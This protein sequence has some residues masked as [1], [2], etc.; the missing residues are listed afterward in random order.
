[1]RAICTALVI[2][3]LAHDASANRWLLDLEPVAIHGRTDGEVGPVSMM[4]VA[5][6]RVFSDGAIAPYAAVGSGF[7]TIQARGGVMIAPRDQSG[8]IAR[9]ELRPQIATIVCAEPAILA[10]AGGGYRWGDATRRRVA[11]IGSVAGGPAWLADDCGPDTTTPQHELH[12]VIGGHVS[13]TF[14]W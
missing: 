8:I 14:D 1:M 7:L 9:I 10:N 5:F 2:A 6:G 12:A 4:V 13:V 3:G 11:V